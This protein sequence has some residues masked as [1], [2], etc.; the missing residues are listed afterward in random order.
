M[1]TCR[2]LAVGGNRLVVN[3]DGRRANGGS[4]VL[5][6]RGNLPRRSPSSNATSM[7]SS[8]S[9]SLKCL[10]AW[11]RF[12]GRICRCEAAS[13]T[14]A[15]AGWSLVIGEASRTSSVENRSGVVRSAGSRPMVPSCRRRG[16]PCNTLLDRKKELGEL[17][18]AMR[19]VRLPIRNNDSPR[20]GCHDIVISQCYSEARGRL[21]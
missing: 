13:A 14:D 4:S 11:R 18:T 16:L 2:R 5:T 12:F 9:P 17:L 6:L 15:A 3:S 21:P 7:S 10:T 1:S 19:K 20:L 8:N